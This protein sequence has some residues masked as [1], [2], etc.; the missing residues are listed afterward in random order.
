M[1]DEV[2]ALRVAAVEQEVEG[3]KLVSPQVLKQIRRNGA[4]IAAMRVSV[5]V[6]KSD[7]DTLKWDVVTLKSDVSSLK[8][9]VTAI[10]S[11]L[12]SLSAKFDALQSNLSRIVADTIREVLRER[13]R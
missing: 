8:S 9:D 3:E 1:V 11:G 2:L 5:G 6:Q 4:D 7:V 12:R 10:K 13:D